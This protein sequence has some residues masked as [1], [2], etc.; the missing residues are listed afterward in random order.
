MRRTDAVSRRARWGALLASALLAVGLVGAL[1]GCAGT[2]A[3]EPAEKGGASGQQADQATTRTVTDSCGRKVEIPAEVERIAASGPVAQ[4]MLLTVAPEKMVGLAGELTADQVAY[5]GDACAELPVFGQIYGGK[6]DF[7]KEAVAAAGPQLIIDVGEPKGSIVEDLDALQE[8]IGIPCIHVDASTVDTY[9]A[10][11]ELLGDVL[12]SERADELAAYCRNAY[13]AVTKA[14][15]A[16]P[17][18]ERVR[19]AYLLGDAGTNAMAKG[20]FQAGV[21]DLVAANVVEVEEPSSSGKGNEVGLEQIA[22]FDPDLIVFAPDSI[23]ASVGDDPAWQGI[24]AIDGGAYYEVPGLP[25]NWLSS[26]ASVNQ[27]LGMQ[28]LARLCYPAQFD[29]DLKDVVVGY[30]DLFYGHELADAEYDALMAHALPKE[31]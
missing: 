26:P 11:Y 4:Q 31:G 20:G 18:A 17:E 13:D 29:D 30:Y 15:D 23:Y 1:G 10:A 24:S 12:G 6:G 2:P 8:Q 16:V 14:V 7:N 27:V 28:W 19:M 25:Y 9:A 22:V 21:V 5:L 3:Q